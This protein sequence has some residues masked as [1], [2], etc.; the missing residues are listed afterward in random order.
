MNF[1]EALDLFEELS[2]IGETCHLF[3]LMYNGLSK[4]EQQKIITWCK[5]RLERV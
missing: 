4:K 3:R 1:D 5:A 2:C